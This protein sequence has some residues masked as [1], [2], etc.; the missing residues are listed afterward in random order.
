LINW[1]NQKGIFKFSKEF[2]GGQ[3]VKTFDYPVIIHNFQILI[4]VDQGHEIITTI[5][6][7]QSLLNRLLFPHICN[8]KSSC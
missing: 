2:L 4:W 7:L 6:Y 8:I 3:I 1:T 5:W